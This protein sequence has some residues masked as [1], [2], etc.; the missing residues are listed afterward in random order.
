MSRDLLQAHERVQRSDVDDPTITAL[1]HVLAEDL[2]GAQRAGEVRVENVGPFFLGHVES[3]RALND[4]G[5]VDE[6]VDFA[7]AL[8]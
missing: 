3:G 8:E 1:Q 2:A 7:E 6:D 4:S 5:A